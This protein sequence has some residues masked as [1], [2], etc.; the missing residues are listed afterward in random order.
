MEDKVAPFICNLMF[1]IMNASLVTYVCHGKYTFIDWFSSPQL[2]EL[3]GSYQVLVVYLKVLRISSQLCFGVKLTLFIIHSDWLCSSCYPTN[4]L[5]DCSLARISSSYDKNTKVGASELLPANRNIF[6]MCTCPNVNIKF[7]SS[8]MV[9][10]LTY[11]QKYEHQQCLPLLIS[12][13]VKCTLIKQ[14]LNEGW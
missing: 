1:N 3:H 13:L 7:W 2:M 14:D 12:L 8:W 4:L 6:N 9:M 5:K 10:S 11:Y